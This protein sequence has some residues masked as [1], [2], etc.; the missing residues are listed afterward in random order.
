MMVCSSAIFFFWYFWLTIQ[1]TAA[2][3]VRNLFSVVA[4][5]ISF[6]L[7][8]A[9]KQEK[10]T[11]FLSSAL[12]PKAQS[13]AVRPGVTLF[14]L[15]KYSKRKKNQIRI[16]PV[17]RAG[18]FWQDFYKSSQVSTL[19]KAKSRAKDKR[20]KERQK[21]AALRCK[22]GVAPPDFEVR[23][24]M[25]RVVFPAGRAGDTRA[26]ICAILCFMSRFRVCVCM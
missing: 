11:V 3:Q 9:Q 5:F 21:Y 13:L 6:P 1:K 25:S 14:H 8:R 22:V 17:V 20:A 15:C 2:S 18:F 7:A 26:A 24:R 4:V 12:T 23:R 16:Y 10:R 19:P